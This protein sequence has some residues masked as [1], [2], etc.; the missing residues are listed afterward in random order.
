M[1]EIQLDKEFLK[2][3][4]QEVLKVAHTDSRKFKIIEHHDRLQ[5]SC[6]ICS[7]S[8]KSPG[9]S[10][11]M[12]GNLYYKN[13]MHICYNEGCK[14]S[15]TSLLKTF[16]VGIDLDKKIGIYNYIDANISYKK[17]DSFVINSLDK[18]ISIDDMVAFFNGD[19]ESQFES[20]GKIQK[21]SIVYQ[22]LKYNRR[23]DNF[24]NLYE[25]KYRITKKWLEPVIV[26]LNKSGDKVLGMQLRNLKSEHHKRLFKNY[27]FEKLYNMLHP[28]DTLDELEAISYNKLSNFYNILNVD[29]EKPVTIFEGYLDSIFYPNSLGAT[30]INSTE[31]M[32]FLLD[33]DDDL[34]LQFFYDQDNIGIRKSIQKLNEGYSVFLWQKLVENLISKKRDK[35][36]AKRFALKIKDLNKLAQDMKD[37][38][39]YDK[40]KLCNYFS[41]DE[42]DTIY[43]DSTLYPDNR[44]EYWQNKKK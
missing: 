5:Y 27:N 10:K 4:I 42:F 39:P 7:D 9:T 1:K 31:D 2:Q 30:G 44:K 33:N 28:D 38:N 11:G 12:R 26:I 21:N 41:S 34:K 36:K 15:I 23:I 17:E 8:M 32:D 24:E 13:L 3:K 16:N 14:M 29:W 19:E 37:G 35:Y 25:A 43:L 6:P 40:L 20:F 18:L 22:H